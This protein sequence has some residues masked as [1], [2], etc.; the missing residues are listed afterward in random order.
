[1]SDYLPVMKKIVVSLITW[2][3]VALGSNE[4]DVPTQG[5]FYAG[6]FSFSF[7]IKQGALSD[8]NP[9][10]VLAVYY[11]TH[12]EGDLTANGFVL[13]YNQE[14]QGA[15]LSAGRGSMRRMG[16]SALPCISESSNFAF[17]VG[18]KVTFNTRLKEGVLYTITNKGGNGKQL[19]I[20]SAEGMRPERKSYN[21]NMNG[22]KEGTP[23]SS[24]FNAHYDSQTIR[25]ITCKQLNNTDNGNY[26]GV[27]FCLKEASQCGRIRLNGVSPHKKH[28][29]ELQSLVIRMGNSVT[30]GAAMAAVLVDIRSKKVLA[31]SDRRPVKAGKNVK[32]EFTKA[33]LKM[34]GAYAIVFTGKSKEELESLIGKTLPPTLPES[35][36]FSTRQ[37]PV[38]DAGQANSW[39]WVYDDLNKIIGDA[40]WAPIAAM[41][42]AGCD[43][44]EE[45]D[46][47]DQAVVVELSDSSFMWGAASA[48]A[49]FGA[50]SV[51]GLGIWQWRKQR[52]AQLATSWQTA[53]LRPCGY[54][55]AG[56]LLL[57]GICWLAYYM[58]PVQQLR[59]AGYGDDFALPGVYHAAETGNVDVLKNMI[60]AGAP[61]TAV[62]A[63]GLTVLHQAALQGHAECV[64]ILLD[65]ADWANLGWCPLHLAV[66][67][68]DEQAV[69]EELS[70]GA[71]PDSG[72]DMGYTPVQFAAALGH[73]ACLEQLLSANGVDTNAADV[74]GNTALHMAARCNHTECVSL[75]LKSPGTQVN[76]RNNA[77]HTALYI[78]TELGLPECVQAIV[79]S[80]RAQ[81]DE[82]DSVGNSLLHLA[83]NKAHPATLNVLINSG[84][85]NVNH[86]NRYGDTA[87]HLAAG[88]GHTQC[89]KNLLQAPDIDVNARQG[90][91]CSA[92]HRACRNGITDCVKLLLETNDVDA[93]MEAEY[94]K[95]TALHFAAE[96]G[97]VDIIEALLEYDDSLLN[98]RN[99]YGYTPLYM[100][101]LDKRTAAVECLLGKDGINLEHKDDD[102]RSI[103]VF[104]IQNESYDVISNLRKAG[105]SLK[106]IDASVLF[107]L[108]D[109]NKCETLAELLKMCPGELCL[110]PVKR[111]RWQDDP[112][113]RIS[114]LAYAVKEG[115][116][117]GVKL[118]L[119]A[120]DF[121]VDGVRDGDGNDLLLAA[122]R[123]GNAE[124]VQ[125]LLDTGRFD[126][127]A[128]N[129]VG[130][131]P[132]R[133]AVTANSPETVRILLSQED[134]EV[135]KGNKAGNTALHK[136]AAKGYA[137]CMKLLLAAEDIDVDARN[138][139]G[140]TPLYWAIKE[141]QAACCRQLKK[142]DA[143]PV[144][145]RG[146]D[147]AYAALCGDAAEVRRLI[148]AGK[149]T[150]AEHL[151][152]GLIC[153]AVRDGDA[154]VLEALTASS[155]ADVN[156]L[157][158]HKPLLYIAA[159]KGYLEC[160]RV[161]LKHPEINPNLRRDDWPQR[162]PLSIAV[163]KGHWDCVDLILKHEKMDFKQHLSND[164]LMKD[165]AESGN[166][167]SFKK[168][169]ALAQDAVPYQN[170][171]MSLISL[172]AAEMLQ[173]LLKHPGFDASQF[174]RLLSYAMRNKSSTGVLVL[175]ADKRCDAAE[176]P[177]EVAALVRQ[178]KK[179]LLEL[180]QD[181]VNFCEQNQTYN[182]SLLRLA[183]LCNLQESVR[184]LLSVPG[185]DANYLEGGW[186]KD[187]LLHAAAG[188]GI[189][190]M[191][192]LLLSFPTVNVYSKS[193]SGSTAYD[194]VE[195]PDKWDSNMLQQRKAECAEILRKAMK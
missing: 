26:K 38:T 79:D 194:Y 182:C 72:D 25:A 117:E 63:A 140:E 90:T 105:C 52:K 61:L 48:L 2:A 5:N 120:V 143:S 67:R 24:L 121:E 101:V 75:L 152:Y 107:N 100:A 74:S 59:R 133:C 150:A 97:H 185:M 112:K 132:L 66:L 176:L 139:A 178:D 95:D 99:K 73:A 172:D 92:L 9:E 16:T 160:V 146:Y 123:A 84:K 177:E 106:D 190:S 169:L 49:L 35:F 50:V 163:C 56:L 103:M 147:L 191:V 70:H 96:A 142:A 98:S 189:P 116:I 125:M 164:L 168:M 41:Q 158:D 138:N 1:M 71:S 173:V 184:T 134:V 18:D 28:N 179:A 130:A 119:E 187:T 7:I 8:K 4:I 34:R 3:C 17:A 159:E 45:D 109:H 65:S 141:S 144:D 14:T 64:E 83:V 166:V 54:G 58:S 53:G 157:F 6:D 136:A 91:R 124:L 170:A 87:L 127:N 11:G 195:T 10:D 135:N 94:R 62:D 155:Y 21:G 51:I 81:L 22:G 47:S 40:K 36:R 153:R 15:I 46:A 108:I 80:G 29:C 69:E 171:A 131:T 33:N 113:Q 55:A 13:Q 85:I 27:S 118:M 183:V 161:L 154:E 137:E 129:C 186:T 110:T 19:V 88:D 20:L 126:V 44:A 151:V 78:A 180:V 86:M 188:A 156:A 57:G 60:A 148:S 115:C 167:E 31:Y 102:N 122:A 149:D 23:M 128:T 174:P 145:A 104:A 30:A 93:S 175:M 77:G 165:Y 32:L 82:V 114:P 162:F 37:V 42:L 68:N 43:S 181:G 193:T 76:K 111:Y 192:K 12:G 39:G 89:L